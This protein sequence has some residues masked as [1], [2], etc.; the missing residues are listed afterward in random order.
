MTKL[1]R[2][3][4]LALVGAL[5]MTALAAEKPEPVKEDRGELLK[6]IIGATAQ[7]DKDGKKLTINATGQVPTGGWKDAKLTPR[8]YVQAPADGVWEFDMTAVRPTG[9]VTQAL[10]KVKASHTWENPPADLKGVKIYGEG[11]GV[12]TVKVGK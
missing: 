2:A 12:K 10:S 6:T 8:T 1:T 9:I 3:L 11:K 5:G 7:F 4:L